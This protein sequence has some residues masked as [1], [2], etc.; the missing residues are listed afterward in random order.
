MEQSRYSKADSHSASQEILRL[1]WNP[2]VHFRI[3]K[4]SPLIPILSQ[5]KPVPPSHAISIKS[6][7]I[8][9]SQLRLSLPSGLFSSCFPTKILYPFLISLMRAVCFAH[10]TLLDLVHVLE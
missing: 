7:L 5:M 8:L 9:S 2:K 6:I 1:L 3:H 4:S 10:L